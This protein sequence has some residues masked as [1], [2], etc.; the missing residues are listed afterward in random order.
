MQVI[1][2]TV[3]IFLLNKLI[4]WLFSDYRFSSYFRATS[5]NG[6]LVVSLIE[7]NIEYFVFLGMR[8]LTNLYAEQFVHKLFSLFVV[9]FLFIIIMF[10]FAGY[11]LLYYFYGKLFKYF[12]DNLF[13]I[14]GSSWMMTLVF[15]V[16]PFLK[17]CIHSLMYEN[18]EG[19]LILL[20]LLDLISFFLMAITQINSL[21]Y[22]S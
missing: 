10:V 6:F 22:K 8:N 3:V 21:N 5:F 20:G 11:F 12:L 14:S 15:C 1:P 19:Q 4:F 2:F 13:R 17:G 18:N 16:R 9:F 7:G